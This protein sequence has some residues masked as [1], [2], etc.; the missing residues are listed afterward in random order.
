MKKMMP[1]WFQAEDLNEFYENGFRFYCKGD[2]S[3]DFDCIDSYDGLPYVDF[4]HYAFDNREEAELFAGQQKV[5]FNSGMHPQ[6]FEIPPHTE[7]WAEHKERSAREEAEKKAKKEAKERAK[8]EEAGLSL[9]EYR[10]EKKR[11]ALVKKI[12]KEIAELEKEIARKRAY[13]EK[14]NKD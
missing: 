1:K 3:V 14:L 13:L 9:E 12:N 11:L 4:A 7:T 2:F 10:A 6:V 5:P 8:A